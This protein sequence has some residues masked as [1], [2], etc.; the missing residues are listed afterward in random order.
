[1]KGQLPYIRCYDGVREMLE[2]RRAAGDELVIVTNG[3]VEQQSDKLRISGLEGCADRVV[4]S[5]AVG[6]AKPAPEIFAT[7]LE[8]RR[9]GL[10]SWMI[11]DHAVN[12][13]QGGH[14]AGCRTGWVTHGATWPGGA[15]PTVSATTTVDVLAQVV[16]TEGR[17]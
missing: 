6:S 1:V 13:I 11:G 7:A 12:D 15:A 14:Q 8:G 16:V 10:R 5:Q 9:P 3:G 4:I 17:D 2:E